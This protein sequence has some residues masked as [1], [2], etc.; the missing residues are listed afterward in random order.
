MLTDHKNLIYFTT[1]RTLNWRQARWSSFLAEYDFE[2]LFQPGIQDGKVD[3]LSR[4]SNFAL[5]PG[6]D[7]NSQQSH[8]LLRP[9][10][11]QMFAIPMLYDDSLLNEIAKATI[12]DLF[13]NEIMACLNAPSPEVKSSNLNQ[14]T[15]PNGLLYH[16]HLLYVPDGS[17]RTRVR[18][19]WWPQPWKFVKEFIKTYDVC[20]RSKMDHHRSYGLLHPL[21]IPSRPWAYPWTL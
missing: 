4:R 17:C 18:G 6:D 16:N 19:F 5:R 2:I 13:A 14:F 8:C 15:T 9:D 1:S 10:Q 20:A 12:S 21:P 7:A 3:A 11:L